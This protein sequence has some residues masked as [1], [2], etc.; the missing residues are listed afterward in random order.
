[1]G[2]KESIESLRPRLAEAAQE[3]ID[4]WEQDEDGCDEEFGSGGICDS[5]AQAMSSVLAKIDGVDLSDGGQDGD[6]HAFVIVYGDKDAYAVDIP[7][8]IY[9]TGGGYSWRKIEG[10]VVR[11]SDVS[12][13]EVRRSDVA[14]DDF[15][16]MAARIVDRE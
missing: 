4:S 16:R 5:V 6:D 9:E 7:P 1:M 13:Y 3:V 15:A 10:A 11:P 12:V 8:G 2:L 14:P